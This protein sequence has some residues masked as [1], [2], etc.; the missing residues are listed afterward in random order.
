MWSKKSKQW[1]QRRRLAFWRIYPPQMCTYSTS[2]TDVCMYV[3][4]RRCGYHHFWGSFGKQQASC[5]GYTTQAGTNTSCWWYCRKSAAR[6]AQL[7]CAIN[8]CWLLNHWNSKDDANS[9][10]CL[11]NMAEDSLNSRQTM[12]GFQRKYFFLF[13]QDKFQEKDRKLKIN[14]VVME[15]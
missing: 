12:P 2:V 15:Y 5:H 7:H 13:S 8:L 10:F 4:V 3:H 1:I 11:E 9:C 6:T 14:G